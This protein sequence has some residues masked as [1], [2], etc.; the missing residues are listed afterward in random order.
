MK[1][2]KEGF[3]LIELLVVIAIIALLMAVIMP[4]LN[5]VKQ[6]ARNV[7][8]QTNL[9]Q[10]GLA[11]LAYLNDNDEHFMD[12][13]EWLFTKAEFNKYGGSGAGAWHDGRLE[14]NGTLW[15]Y[16]ET[17]DSHVCPSYMALAQKHADARAI[18]TAIPIDPQYTYSMNGFFG[19]KGSDAWAGIYLV[20]KMHQVKRPSKVLYFCEEGLWQLPTYN[21]YF[22]NDTVMLSRSHAS[23]SN[24]DGQLCDSLANFHKSK[25][26]VDEMKAGK[27]GESNFVLL[28]GSIESAH[29]KDSFDWSRPF[30]KR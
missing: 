14:P 24:P 4:S 16:M 3:T 18:N 25:G 23:D 17:D 26:S 2:S 21:Q 15:P 1:K 6:S 5:K 8:C 30:N 9:H 13:W 22:L 7:V 19:P 28:D 10:Y 20:Q 29:P 27:V 12:H 11:G